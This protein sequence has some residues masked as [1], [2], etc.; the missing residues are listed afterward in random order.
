MVVNFIMP[1]EVLS[2]RRQLMRSKPAKQP[3]KRLYEPIREALKRK[4]STTYLPYFEISAEGKISDVVKE[5][6]D[7]VCLHI[8]DFESV[9]PDIIGFLVPRTGGVFDTMNELTGRIRGNPTSEKI[10]VEVK[11]ER[12]LISH[13]IQTKMYAEVFG[14]SYAF[15]ITTRPI[16]E[17]IKRFDK[18]KPELLSYGKGRKLI[19]GRFDENTTSRMPDFDASS[20]Y[21]P[22]STPFPPFSDLPWKHPS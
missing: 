17:Q 9:K 12:L 18:M 22:L 5:T 14:A 2:K 10:V 4:F 11:D 1:G 7:D 19:L 21:P 8:I 13:L 16:P 15:L 20:W 6:L 3:E